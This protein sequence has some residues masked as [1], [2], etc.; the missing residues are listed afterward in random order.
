MSSKPPAPWTRIRQG[1][2]LD[3]T[4]LKVR[5]DT[6]ADPRDGAHHPRVIIDAPDWVNIIPITRE[7]RVVLIRQFRFG[8]WQRTLELPGGIVD[9]GEDPQTAA[10]REL[11]EETGYRPGQVIPL[12]W[13]HPNP[14]IQ[15]NRCHSYLALDCDQVHLGQPEATEDITVEL[16]DRAEI[17]G[18]ILGG[19]ISHALVVT[20]FYLQAH[21]R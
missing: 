8:V 6:V 15:S 18:L 9:P 21:R 5:E 16:R 11:E 7:G 13:V 10:I 2:P 19:E 4:I 14:A 3:L 17:P 12:G 20:A 1:Q